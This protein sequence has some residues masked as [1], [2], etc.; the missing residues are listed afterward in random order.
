[1][2]RFRADWLQRRPRDGIH[3]FQGQLMMFL[4]LIDVL[5]ISEAFHIHLPP[6]SLPRYTLPLLTEKRQ[7]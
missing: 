6:F 2:A 7:E 4:V 1:M 3:P 5:L